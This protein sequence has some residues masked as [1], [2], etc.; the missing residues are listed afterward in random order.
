MKRNFLTLTVCFVLGILAASQLEANDNDNL[1]SAF[2]QP[3]NSDKVSPVGSQLK[4]YVE[5]LGVSYESSEDQIAY[6]FT[7][8][9]E[10]IEIPTNMHTTE[11]GSVWA[12]FNLASIPAEANPADYAQHLLNLLQMS[13]ENGDY[14]FSYNPDHRMIKIYGCLQTSNASIDQERLAVYIKGMAIA[15]IK[16]EK[17]WN[18]AAWNQ[19]LPQ[20]VGTWHADSNGMQLTLSGSGGFELKV[21]GQVMSGQYQI[22]GD[23]LS[24][25][26]TKGESI[27]GKIRLDNGNQFTLIVNGQQIV[28]VRQ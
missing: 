9:H 1:T 26:D 25:K 3:A 5:S 15:A 11:A 10:G 8:S 18:P 14:F 21:N 2:G 28:F 27:Q 13:G 7:Y 19:Q 17:Y 16:T 4:Q 22:D 23:D 20:H 6:S 12:G 24:M